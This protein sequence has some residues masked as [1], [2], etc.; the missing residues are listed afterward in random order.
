MWG[1]RAGPTT[2]NS[3]I[4]QGEGTPWRKE[5]PGSSVLGRVSVTASL[6]PAKSAGNTL[7]I[8]GGTRVRSQQISYL[9][10]FPRSEIPPRSSATL[11]PSPFSATLSS[12]ISFGSRSPR[13][14]NDSAVRWSPERKLNSSCESFL[15]RRSSLMR[16]ANALRTGGCIREIVRV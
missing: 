5:R 3:A 14:I 16:E 15:A 6:T 2:I 9:N 11:I 7:R 12:V 1:Q 13:S 8:S 10:F 4:S